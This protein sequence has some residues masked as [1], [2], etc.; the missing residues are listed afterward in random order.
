MGVKIDETSKLLND[1]Y[2]EKHFPSDETDIGI[3]MGNEGQ[4]ILPKF[5]KECSALIRIPQYG[6][7]TASLN[8]NVATNIVLHR[9]SMWKRINRI[10]NNKR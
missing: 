2:F 8:V 9:F 6:V 7:G 1:E 4:G 5:L 3:L 10:N